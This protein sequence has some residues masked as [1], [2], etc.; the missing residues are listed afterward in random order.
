MILGSSGVVAATF[1][2][3]LCK[4]VS[5]ARFGRP[6]I[7]ADLTLGELHCKFYSKLLILGRVSKQRLYAHIRSGA[8]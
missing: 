7:S 4:K 3:G 6:A 5:K 2:R 8:T 1:P